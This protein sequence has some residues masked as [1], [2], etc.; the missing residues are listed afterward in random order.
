MVFAVK[1]FNKQKLI[2]RLTLSVEQSLFARLPKMILIWDSPSNPFQAA[3]LH[4]VTNIFVA[5]SSD[6]KILTQ[7][8]EF[9]MF[10]EMNFDWLTKNDQL[11]WPIWKIIW[12]IKSLKFSSKCFWTEQFVSVSARINYPSWVA[13]CLLQIKGHQNLLLRFT[14][15]QTGKL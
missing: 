7:N 1:F 6:S 12:T 4:I 15:I 11:R 3:H 8:R 2:S 5:C 14:T 10:Y 13:V 9:M